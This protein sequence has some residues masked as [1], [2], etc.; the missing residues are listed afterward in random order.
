M[1]DNYRSVSILLVISKI[2]PLLSK[3]HYGF[4]KGYS[5]RDCLLAMLEHFKSLDKKKGDCLSHELIIAK[6]NA[7]G[8]NLATLKLV[9]N[10]LFK[11]TIKN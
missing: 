11:M 9:L 7:C 1:K 3:F 4:R 10:Y 6:L 2:D 5:A 8:F